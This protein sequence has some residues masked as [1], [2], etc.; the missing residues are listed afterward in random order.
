[1]STTI[2][3]RLT[4]WPRD[5]EVPARFAAVGASVREIEGTD[6]GVRG[7]KYARGLERV[8][9]VDVGSRG[10]DVAVFQRSA[11][12]PGAP[13][14]SKRAHLVVIHRAH[15]AEIVAVQLIGAQPRNVQEAA[16]VEI[17]RLRFVAS[18]AGAEAAA[19]MQRV[20]AQNRQR[21]QK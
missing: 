6:I 5:E 12:V 17:G 4:S 9:E 8:A 3:A 15:E 7:E 1:M 20:A 11:K 10:P 14:V 2:R 18:I 19:Q 13:D 21:L 16:E